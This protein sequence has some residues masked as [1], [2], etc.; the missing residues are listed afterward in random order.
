M[1]DLIEQALSYNTKQ[2]LVQK[3]QDV[4]TSVKFASEAFD[5]EKQ[6]REKVTTFGP[7]LNE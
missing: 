6:S 7:E 5:D 2:I 3:Q 4:G 1:C